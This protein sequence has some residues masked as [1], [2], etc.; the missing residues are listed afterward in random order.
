[1]RFEWAKY[2]RSATWGLC[3]VA[4][5]LMVVDALPWGWDLEG[6]LD[7]LVRVVALITTGVLYLSRSGSSAAVDIYLAGVEAGRRDAAE[8]L[9]SRLGASADK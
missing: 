2:A 1:M 5:A 3:V 4:W 8:R 6:G 9:R 7:G